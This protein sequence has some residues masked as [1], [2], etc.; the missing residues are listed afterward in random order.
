MTLLGKLIRYTA[1]SAI[2][3]SVS[4]AVLGVLVATGTTSAT[5]ANVAATAI[6]SIPSFELNR[7]WVWSKTGHRSLLGEVGPFCALA[8][9]G[10]ALSTAA[11]GM[12]ARWAS[13]AGLGTA[14]RTVVVEAAHMA[15]FGGLWVLQFLLLDRA[16]FVHVPPKELIHDH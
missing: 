7:R 1:V 6:G 5:L 12:A 8:F 2:S 4:L 13:A 9:A 11:V 14:A 3:T 16:L 10:L 15:G